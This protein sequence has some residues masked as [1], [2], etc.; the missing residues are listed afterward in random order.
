MAPLVSAGVGLEEDDR[1]GADA[2]I[3]TFLADA[4]AGD[5]VANTELTDTIVEALRTRQ[6]PAEPGTKPPA[7]RDERA[8]PQNGTGIPLRSGHPSP[9]GCPGRGPPLADHAARKPDR[10]PADRRDRVLQLH[11]ATGFALGY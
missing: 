3:A 9:V 8:S 10:A 7:D 6:R 2:L 11:L 5:D 1:A 4:D